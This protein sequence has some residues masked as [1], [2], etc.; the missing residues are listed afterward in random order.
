MGALPP[1]MASGPCYDA[2]IHVTT[3]GRVMERTVGI[4]GLRDGL[5]RHL[6]RVRRGA[7]LVI[8][9]RGHPVAIIVPYGPGG[10]PTRAE[11]LR[12]LLASGHVSPAERPFLK[13]VP[14]VRGRGRLASDLIS[15]SRR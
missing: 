12:T 4:R 2:H 9:D 7:R 1:E 11:R 6:G 10:D 15:D 3:K 13:R 8:T 5:T 14:L